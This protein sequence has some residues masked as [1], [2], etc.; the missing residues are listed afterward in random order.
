MKITR[1]YSSRHFAV[2]M[3]GSALFI[4][5]FFPVLVSLA[6]LSGIWL[7]GLGLIVGLIWLLGSAKALL[8]INAAIMCLPEYKRALKAQ[9]AAQLLI[10]PL[11]SVLFLIN[12]LAALH[13]SE[14][15]WRGIIYELVSDKETRIVDK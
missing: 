2:S 14:I 11:S 8:R 15:T 9:Y 7:Y 6:F 13:S 1:V 12:D 5:T 3:I 10:W 4:L